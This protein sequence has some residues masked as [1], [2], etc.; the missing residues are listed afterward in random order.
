MIDFEE[1]K[2]HQE[3]GQRDID[4]LQNDERDILRHYCS[5]GTEAILRLGVQR[6]APVDEVVI[7]A[8][9]SG[10]ALGLHLQVTAGEVRGR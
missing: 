7:N 3:E 8:F 10:I 4:S 5:L 9:R 6:K 2:Q 1:M